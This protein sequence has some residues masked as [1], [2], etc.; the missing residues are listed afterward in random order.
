M[1]ETTV[2][3]WTRL[4]RTMVALLV[5]MAMLLCGCAGTGDKETEGKGNGNGNGNNSLLGGDGDGKL[6]TEDIVGGMTGIYGSLLESLGGNSNMPT[7]YEMDMTVT[8]GETLLSQ[9]GAV[10]ESQGMSGDMSWFQSLGL[11]M[12]VTYKDNLGGMNVSASINGTEVVALEA[13]VDMLAGMVYMCIPDLSNECVG[14]A[15]DMSGMIVSYQQILT[16]MEEY[17]DIVSALPT[18]KE[19]NT[20]LTRYVD[21]A[22]GAMREPSTTTQT[23]SHGGI[24]Q[25]VTTTSYAISRMDVLN[26]AEA[27][28]NTAKTDADLEKI[29]DK[30]SD[31]LNE[32]NATSGDETGEGPAPMDLHASIMSAAENA[33]EGIADAK[34]GLESGD[35]ENLDMLV[36]SIFTDDDKQV[37]FQLVTNN[38]WDTMETCAYSLTSG[39]NTAL[40][41]DVGGNNRLQGTGTNV[42][43]KCNGNYSL[44]MEGREM[45]HIGVKDLDTKA[46]KNGKLQGTFSLRFSEEMANEMGGMITSN[47]TIELGLNIGGGKSQISLALYN[48]EML[49]F[50]VDL[51]AKTLSGGNVRVPSN[52]VDAEDEDAVMEWVS[53]MDFDKILRNLRSAGVSS[54]LVDMLETALDNAM[55]G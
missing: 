53:A 29:L 9:L 24:S 34:A 7:G 47:M 35:V 49:F 6:E 38:G 11:S 36:F 27:V 25:E 4:L 42:G 51:S 12:A 52:Y 3:S 31:W 32:Q 10:L 41:V 22:K 40:Y 8:V 46:L 33:L 17:A 54:E 1:K 15:T 37:G 44:V 13:V 26:I 28:L 14:V 19:L 39:E 50:R 18:E 20:L 21:I 16:Q 43:G 48:G 5:V 30:L 23:L 45:M 2:F 55:N